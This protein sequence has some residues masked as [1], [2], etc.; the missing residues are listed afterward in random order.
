VKPAFAFYMIRHG[1]T[2]WNREQRFQGRT[3]IPLNAL[4]VEQAKANGRI[5]AALGLDW[6]QWHF[7]SSPLS[8]ARQTMEL[9]RTQLNLTPGD[10]DIDD[11]LIEVTFGDWERRTLA[12]LRVAQPETMAQ[13]D[14]SKWD[15]IPPGGESYKQACGRVRFV[16]GALPGPSVIVT[17]GGVIRA[18]R[19]EVE[20]LA[21]NHAAETRIPQ[22]DIYHFDG[23]HGGWMNAKNGSHPVLSPQR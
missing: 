2:D 12:E 16:L 9:V 1:E 19:H 17:H 23:L 3:D 11:A 20:G 15:F 4:G 13:R 21:G 5:L 6:T 14:A 22:D 10:H 7:V 18:M 8:R